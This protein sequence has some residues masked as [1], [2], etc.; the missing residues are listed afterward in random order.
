MLPCHLWKYDWICYCKPNLPC[1]WTLPAVHVLSLFP[2]C[3]CQWWL[4]SLPRLQMF[5]TVRN[6][7][8][9]KVTFSQVCVKNSVP[10][11]EGVH[12]QADRHPEADSHPQVGQDYVLHAS[13]ILFRGWYPSM[14][15]R[16]PGPWPGGAWGVWPGPH[17]GGKFQFQYHP[18]L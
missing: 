5:F 8:C 3:W 11:G 17:P 14:P 12:P 1:S 16:L 9:K 18:L 13:A 4:E 10:G 15:C 2:T 7:R 6:S